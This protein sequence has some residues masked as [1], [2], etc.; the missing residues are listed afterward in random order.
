MKPA[1]LLMI[2]ATVLA[3]MSPANAQQAERDMS[4]MSGGLLLPRMDAPG[5]NCLLPKAALSA[6]RSTAWAA[7]T[8][9]HWM[10]NSWN[11]R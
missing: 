7:K 3:G 5:A 8:P 10:P 9:Q 4:M 6:T 11:C 1:T 2:T